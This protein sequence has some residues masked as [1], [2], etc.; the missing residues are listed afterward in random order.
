MSVVLKLWLSDRSGVIQM[1][2]PYA[3]V[4]T[5]EKVRD[6]LIVW[7]SISTYCGHWTIDPVIQTSGSPGED[8][9]D[10]G[11]WTPEIIADVQRRFSNNE[12]CQHCKGLHARACPRVKSMTFH[13]NGSLASIEFW[14][15]GE[16]SDENV[17]WPEE[18]PDSAETP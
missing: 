3:D 5:A 15:D 11:G 18:V 6:R 10:D 17:I 12:A 1:F 14:P 7:P 13:S 9:Q 2:G 16:W 4:P 8:L